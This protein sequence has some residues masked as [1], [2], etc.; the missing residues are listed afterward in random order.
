M[1]R[2]DI[3]TRSIDESIWSDLS[4]DTFRQ[5]LVNLEETTNAVPIAPQYFSAADWL[6][7]SPHDPN[8]KYSLPRVVE[9]RLADD[10]ASLVA[11]DEGA[12]SVA[13]VCVEQHLGPPSLTLRFATLDI[14]LNN[15][16]K[17]ALEGWPSI[18]S[19]VDA[20][21]EEN[22]SNAMKVLYHSIVRLHR[23]RL[24][25]RLRSSHWEKP[26]YLSKSHKKPLL[27]DIDNLIHR[28]QFSYTRKEAESRLQVEKHLRDLVSTYQ[29][30]ENISGNHLEDLYS[31][32]AASF[33]FCSAAS[34]QDFLWTVPDLVEFGEP[35]AE[36]MRRI[37][38]EV[39]DEVVRHTVEVINE[40]SV[41]RMVN[42]L[43][44]VCHA[45][46]GMKTTLLTELGL[47]RRSVMA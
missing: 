45:L 18:L 9:Q 8:T 17:T 43:V 20:D 25:A 5:H 1:E 21:R 35:L 46:T 13:A 34:I 22:G 33:E 37:V 39:D 42:Q 44:F 7:V 36:Q 3:R 24:L 31:L 28:A 10:F 47:W 14:S 32:V 16:T 29:A 38:R 26:K 11:V 41:E 12:Q 30:F 6:P 19:T 27:K 23:R 2:K 15:K 4:K 40:E